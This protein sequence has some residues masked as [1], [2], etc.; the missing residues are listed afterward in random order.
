MKRACAAAAILT[1]AVT[2]FLGADPLLNRPETVNGTILIFPDHAKPGI[3]YYMPAGLALAR[4]FGAPQFFFY[5]YVYVRP[6]AGAGSETL[7]G[8]VLAL[9]VEFTDETETLRRLKGTSFEYRPVP[10]D[11]I[12]CALSYAEIGTEDPEAAKTTLAE[13]E[14]PWTKKSFT[15]PLRRESA[16][17]LWKIF[18]ER[19][20]TGLSVECEFAFSGYELE[21][22]T[23]KEGERSS[24][25]SLAVPVSMEDNPG[26]FKVIN[27]ADKVAFNYRRMSVLCFDFANGTNGETVKLTAEIEIVTAK[28][29]RDFKTVSFAAGTEPQQDLEFAVPEAKGGRYRYR[30]TRTT[31]D[32][33]AEKTDWAEGDDTFLDLTTYEIAV[34]DKT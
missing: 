20:S 7:A 2:V 30:V 5:K 14:L 11:R 19:K 33:R 15:L 21:E 10:V 18:E 22:N 13:R 31:G 32:G 29:Q 4:T 34:K 25:L 12:K 9:S 24:R 6:D 1:A 23:Y 3:F 16:T 17:L 8:A 26:L 28:G 27:L